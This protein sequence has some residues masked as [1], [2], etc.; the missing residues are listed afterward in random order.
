MRGDLPNQITHLRSFDLREI[1]GIETRDLKK[2][3]KITNYMF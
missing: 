1:L 2:S 3:I